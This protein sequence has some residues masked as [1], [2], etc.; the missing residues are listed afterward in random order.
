M[1]ACPANYQRCNAFTC[2][3]QSQL[4]PI[5][6]IQ[7]VFAGTPMSNFSGSAPLNQ[8]EVI[9]F[10]RE[11]AVAGVYGLTVSVNDYPCLSQ[12]KEPSFASKYPLYAL[13]LGCGE[14]GHDIKN[15]KLVGNMNY[16]AF[17]SQSRVSD[18]ISSLTNFQSYA[19][20]NQASLFARQQVQYQFAN[21]NCYGFSDAPILTVT[22][23]VMNIKANAFLYFVIKLV[24]IFILLIFIGFE[25][26]LHRGR[27]DV[28]NP[29]V[30]VSCEIML[31]VLLGIILMEASFEKYYY[32]QKTQ[33]VSK[34]KAIGKANCFQQDYFNQ[35]LQNFPELFS[36]SLENYDTAILANFIWNGIQLFV[37]LVI[38]VIILRNGRLDTLDQISY[39]S[40]PARHRKEDNATD[41]VEL[42]NQEAK[43]IISS[44]YK[45]QGQLQ[46]QN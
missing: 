4:C 34:Y 22:Q 13:T 11:S 20:Q 44:F 37:F 6:T 8:E 25:V 19:N 45:D 21:A 38:E 33:M 26:S 24:L 27:F 41:Y 7:I 46:Q 36:S 32:D 43:D 31:F 10:W 9:Y 29:K 39:F 16:Y 1:E 3:H 17:L 28:I 40:V 5:T 2:V 18:D 14:Y 42:P 30:T 15:S 12:S 23:L 35:I